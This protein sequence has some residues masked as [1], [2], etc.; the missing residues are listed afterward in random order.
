MKECLQKGP[1]KSMRKK[2]KLIDDG[3][4]FFKE[5]EYVPYVDDLRNLIMDEFHKGPYLG[6]L[7]Y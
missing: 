4:L 1:K 3:L 6:H 2:Y 5:K 7:G